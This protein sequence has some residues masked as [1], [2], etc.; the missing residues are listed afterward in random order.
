M[1]WLAEI[2][3]GFPAVG[4]VVA[5]LALISLLELVLPH[6]PRNAWSTRRLTANLVLGAGTLALNLIGSAGL[7]VLLAWQAEVGVGLLRAFALPPAVELVIVLVVLDFSFYVAH[8]S[9]HATPLFW[10]YHRIHHADPHVDATTTLRQHPG[11]SVI[12]LAYTTAFATLL[13]ASPAAYATYRAAVALNALLEHADIRVPRR[14]DDA[15]AIVTTWPGFHKLHHSRDPRFTDSNYGNLLSCWDRFFGTRA[16][17][18]LGEPVAYGLAGLDDDATQSLRG[19]LALPRRLASDRR[20]A[21]RT[22]PPAAAPAP[23]SVP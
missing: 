7:A 3:S 12:R 5:A 15:L 4:L 19:L 11:E 13:G 21:S 10:R 16:A 22:S 17:R 9:M 18:P 6:F 1:G 20:A 14:L 23:G 2:R 8:V